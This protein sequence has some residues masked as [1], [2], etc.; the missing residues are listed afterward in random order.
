MT[1]SEVSKNSQ[2]VNFG[3]YLFLLSVGR[4]DAPFDELFMQLVRPDMV[5]GKKVPQDLNDL[6]FGELLRLQEITDNTLFTLPAKVLLKVSEERVM[7]EE[8]IKVLS[9][10]SF[11]VQELK[12]IGQVFASTNVPPTPEEIKAGV[13][14]LDFG[15]FG[16]IDYYAKRM[17]I[18]DHDK[19]LRFPWV[20]VYKC[21]EMDAK[22]NVYERNLREIYAKKK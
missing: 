13:D 16:L 15:P 14:K 19:V 8:A 4:L 9:F 5:F 11:V 10:S 2:R 7:E 6:T 1:H 22:K 12:R 21:L 3:M 17:G 20:R 18:Q